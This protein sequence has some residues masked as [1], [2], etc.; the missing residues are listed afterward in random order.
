[1][2][3]TAKFQSMDSINTVSVSVLAAKFKND[4]CSQNLN[5]TD[6]PNLTHINHIHDHSSPQP[7]VSSP[8][9]PYP[10]YAQ[11]PIHGVLM[12]DTWDGNMPK[13]F[14]HAPGLQ[15][16]SCPHIRS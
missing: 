10:P 7:P 12:T 3:V 1:M 4:R 15:K 2:C 11:Q 13:L 5:H 14:H 9:A 6:L 16:H 8:L